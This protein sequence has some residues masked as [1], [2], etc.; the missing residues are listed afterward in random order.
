M[1]LGKSRA[2]QNLSKLLMLST[3]TVKLDDKTQAKLIR[4]AQSRRYVVD[5]PDQD[6]GDAATAFTDEDF[7]K[8]E[9]EY[10]CQ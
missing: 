7:E 2:D 5:E 6:A 8:F 3:Q 9:R 1:R 10:F 4:R